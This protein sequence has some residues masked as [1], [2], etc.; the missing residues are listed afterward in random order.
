LVEHQSQFRQELALVTSIP[1]IGEQTAL[2]LL[3]ELYD[4]AAYP[5]ANAVDADAGLSPA[6]H[7]SGH[8]VHRRPKLCKVGKTA[9]R[10]ALYL[11]ALNAIRHNPIVKHLADRLKAK[12]KLPMVI[13]GA[14]MRKLLHLVYGVLKHQQ[15]FDPH[16]AHSIPTPP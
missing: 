1:G 2:K 5:T 14:A 11:P 16:W 15:P 4:I 10:A 8:S 13:I 3:A 7:E 6:K 12:G 9:V